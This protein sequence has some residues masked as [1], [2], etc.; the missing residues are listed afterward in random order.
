[1]W[2]GWNFMQNC[3]L[4]KKN[5]NNKFIKCARPNGDCH[6]QSATSMFEARIVQNRCFTLQSPTPLQHF[7]SCCCFFSDATRPELVWNSP[8]L[9]FICLLTR[10]HKSAVSFLLLSCV[11]LVLYS[12][13]EST[14][15]WRPWIPLIKIKLGVLKKKK[16][17][18]LYFLSCAFVVWNGFVFFESYFFVWLLNKF[19]MI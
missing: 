15:L 17:E 12:Y 16:L 13:Q 1:M 7:S 9:L 5:N 8:R 19:I 10:S 4:V 2:N 14:L 3:P 6:R 18:G 11:V